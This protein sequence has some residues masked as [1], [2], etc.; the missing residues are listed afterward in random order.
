MVANYERN[1]AIGKFRKTRVRVSTNATKSGK[2]AIVVHDDALVNI[3]FI[4]L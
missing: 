4:K 1:L 3:I 2:D